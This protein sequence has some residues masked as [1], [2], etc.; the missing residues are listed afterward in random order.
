MFY[1]LLI[2]LFP[3]ALHAETANSTV[4]KLIAERWNDSTVRVEWSFN[5]EIPKVL[6]SDAEWTLVE[7]VP[8]RLAGS[9]ILK[10]QTQSNEDQ[11]LLVIISGTAKVYGMC[12]TVREK[13][14]A[15]DPVLKVNLEEQE[16]EWTRLTA[17][18]LKESDF[19]G[20]II[21]RHALIPGRVL[22]QEDVKSAPVVRNGEVIKVSYQVGQIRVQSIARALA[23]GSVGET[24]TVV[25]NNGK[26]K[27]L[28]AY[29]QNKNEIQLLL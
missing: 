17:K 21:A 9:L 16:L 23:D 18:P 1:L 28:K 7:P 26:Q 24:I 27:R 11:K 25:V 19:N 20:E 3:F 10:L 22:T 12:Y 2:L 13:I 6:E 15:G 8:D 5:G 4:E 29:I 14:A